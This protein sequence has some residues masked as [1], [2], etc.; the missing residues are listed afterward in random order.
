MK[1]RTEVLKLILAHPFQTSRGTPSSSQTSVVVALDDG[2]VEGLGEA[3]SCGYLNQCATETEKALARMREYLPA[4]PFAIEDAMRA[5]EKHFPEFPAARCAIDIALHDLV[6]KKLG[7]PLHKYFG[8]S[9]GE[10]RKTSF[11]IGLDSIEGIAAKVEEARNYSILKVKLGVP[12]D[13]EIIRAVRKLTDA[14]L[15]VD[16]NGAW[17]ADEAA[18][19]MKVLA[20][21]G[22]EFVEQPLPREDLAGHAK[23]KKK[24]ILPIILD[25]TI[26]TSKDI[27]AAAAACDGVNIKLTKAGGLREAARMIATARACGLKVMLG[28]MVASSVKITA[29]AHLAPLADYL[30]L[31]GN[32]LVVNDP[33]RGVISAFGEMLLPDGPGLGL[34]DAYEGRNFHD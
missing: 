34:V 25:E 20:E 8:L 10:A 9:A 26:Q 28:C 3:A 7:L 33:Y 22:V 29:A 4:D 11:T 21:L 14:T 27:P 30:D 17:K 24:G 5:L 13:L 12:D 18:K 31:D 19:K 23:L 2:G 1:L 6:G 15:R 16:A 32:L